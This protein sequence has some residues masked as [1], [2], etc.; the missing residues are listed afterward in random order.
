MAIA[1]NFM[2]LK[3]ALET[4]K[5]HLVSNREIARNTS[6]DAKTVGKFIRADISLLYFS[7]L[8]K[9]LRYFQKEGLSIELG[10]FFC[11]QGEELASNIGPNIMKLDPVPTD[12]QITQDTGIPILRVNNLVRGN[13]KRVYLTD[14]AAL[15]AYFRQR[16]LEIELGDLLREEEVE[17][18][19]A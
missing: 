14:L 18:E 8:S 9:L 5:M 12:E 7:T 2:A 13:V 6:V 16:G 3:H 4:K 10:D 19:L 11:W 17:R 15:L 1:P